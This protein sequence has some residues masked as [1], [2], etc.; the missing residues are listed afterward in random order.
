MSRSSQ[1][2]L[3]PR[4]IYNLTH[5]K[6]KLSMKLLLGILAIFFFS[7][8]IL[9]IVTI[10]SFMPEIIASKLSMMSLNVST[11]SGRINESIERQ[12]DFG[13]SLSQSHEVR[14]AAL[15]GSNP[16]V[17]SLLEN[18]NKQHTN[19]KDI[20]ISDSSG[21]IVAASHSRVGTRLANLDYFKAA[22]NGSVFISNVT[23][24]QDS[25]EMFYAISFPIKSGGQ[26]VGVLSLLMQ[27]ESVMRDIRGIYEQA[28]LRD[29]YIADTAGL[30]IDHPNH[31]NILTKSIS[32]LQLGGDIL[33]KPHDV[34]DQRKLGRRNWIAY[35]R[36]P[37]TGWIVISQMSQS[38]M[39][40]T[41]NAIRMRNLFLLLI[42][43]VIMGFF[44]HHFQN[45]LVL[46]PL[47]KLIQC[48]NAVKSGHLGVKANI[49]TGDELEYIGAHFNQMVENI[50]TLIHNA[51]SI[52]NDV[53]ESIINLKESSKS[54]AQAAE[55][56][57][58]TMEQITRGTMDQSQHAEESTVYMKNLSQH[59]EAIVN[60]A[61]VMENTI[62]LTKELSAKSN[63]AVSDLLN[64]ANQTRGITDTIIENTKQLSANTTEIRKASDA[65]EAVA[66][67]TNLL[68]LNASIEAARAGDAGLG[69]AVVA[70]E[71]NKL[72]EQS[73]NAVASI[74][75]MS[76]TI[77]R[78]LDTSSNNASQA[79]EIVNE[80]TA[81]VNAANESFQ[82]ITDQMNQFLKLISDMTTFIEKMNQVKEKTLSAI[83]NISAISQETAAATEEVS[84]SAEE[85]TSMA[86]QVNVLASDL[87]SISDRLV[88]AI[89]VFSVSEEF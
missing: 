67:Q 9:I 19:L 55:E 34:V 18:L 45:H 51:Q 66:V 16:S 22:R 12:K 79:Y 50:K 44:V 70:E 82:N 3:I 26:V 54:S 49:S 15:N 13:L 39:F 28:G 14:N 2:S 5:F 1:R 32:E 81:A 38:K 17:D 59:I 76:Q 65:I 62:A 42:S 37:S 43:V 86:H 88:S 89:E 56:V 87:K 83:V 77:L 74:N 58:S 21:T 72:S 57:A 68:A 36:V 8:N 10:N 30:Y 24:A 78:Q 69:F 46:K 33:E 48:M 84:S 53:K 23:T 73:R 25:G 20:Q 71:I 27:W 41:L 63:Q 7:C 47:S 60:Q 64:K 75:S 61:Q 6:E 40:A 35:H 11:V 80:Q 29:T 4:I 52:V 85:Q 31:Q